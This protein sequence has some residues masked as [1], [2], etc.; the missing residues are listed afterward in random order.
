[1]SILDA[2]ESGQYN[3]VPLLIGSNSQEF[4]LLLGS[5]IKKD[6]GLHLTKIDAERLIRTL[7]PEELV[8]LFYSN[9]YPKVSKNLRTALHS[10][11]SDLTFNGPVKRI[12]DAASR[13]QPNQVYMYRYDEAPIRGLLEKGAGHAI[14]LPLL[15]GSSRI[16][17]SSISNIP[18]LLGYIPAKQRKFIAQFRS[19]WTNFVH[20]HQP[21][22]LTY[23]GQTTAAV[24]TPYSNTI[25]GQQVMLLKSNPGAQMVPFNSLPTSANVNAILPFLPRPLAPFSN[26]AIPQACLKLF[27]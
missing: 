20:S 13:Y 19:N 23:G 1:M 16:L 27:R 4:G 5:V 7:G 18:N 21:N 2:F 15:F 22:S 25:E 6:F 14:E 26:S 10:F 17:S 8:Q 11:L 24:W 3:K 9:Y 12:A